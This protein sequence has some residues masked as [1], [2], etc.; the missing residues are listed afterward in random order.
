M[1]ILTARTG[2]FFCF[3]I[4]LIFSL[5]KSWFG[6]LLFGIYILGKSGLVV[7]LR[8]SLSLNF[9]YLFNKSL[10]FPFDITR[11]SCNITDMFLCLIVTGYI[12]LSF[13]LFLHIVLNLVN[14]LKLRSGVGC[15]WL[16][17]FRSLGLLSK[18]YSCYYWSSKWHP[19]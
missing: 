8:L 4:F 6:Q 2:L 13:K 11:G 19:Y 17:S 1:K 9:N 14:S 5:S 10:I 7:L 18:G 15:S 16:K 3:I 12:V